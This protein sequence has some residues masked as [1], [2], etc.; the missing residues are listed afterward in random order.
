M[1]STASRCSTFRPVEPILSRTRIPTPSMECSNERGISLASNFGKVYERIID[2]RIKGT[3]RISESQAGGKKGQATVDHIITLKQI[4]ADIRQRRKTAYV[5][6]LDVEKAYD[7]AWLEAIMYVMKKIG[8]EGRN[9]LMMKK[10]NSNLK[11]KIRTKDGLTREIKL[12]DSIRQGGVLS[13]GQYAAMMDEIAKEIT[14]RGEGLKIQP[15]GQTGCLLWMDDVA[16]IHHDPKELQKMLTTT[17]EVA[18]MK[19]K[20]KYDQHWPNAGPMLAQCWL[21][22][23]GPML[24]QH[25][26]IIYFLFLECD[27]HWP[28][29]GPMLAQCRLAY[30]GPMLDQCSTSIGPMLGQ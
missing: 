17:E 9:W 16:L 27:Q 15:I 18:N 22:N 21:A 23:I 28:N 8:V 10:L 29:A 25:W 30:I 13:V 19:K 11:A 6:F 7:K 14:V 12:K 2:N 24:G 3:A 4:V 1:Y 20:W 26:A 5:V